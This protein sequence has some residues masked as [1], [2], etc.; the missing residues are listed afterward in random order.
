MRT[1]TMF[2]MLCLGILFSVLCMLSACG[3]QEL[4][5][6]GGKTG[7]DRE[8]RDERN[9]R[10]FQKSLDIYPWKVYI[11]TAQKSKEQ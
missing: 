10:I 4:P 8:N 2:L 7:D 11:Y 1:R 6:P 3:T 9:L 5:N